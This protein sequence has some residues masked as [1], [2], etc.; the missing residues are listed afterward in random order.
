LI[1]GEEVVESN[2]LQWFWI[3]DRVVGVRQ[4]CPIARAQDKWRKFRTVRKVERT[5]QQEV[6]QIGMQNCL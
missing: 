5:G 6:L 2:V 3:R 4:I 1:S